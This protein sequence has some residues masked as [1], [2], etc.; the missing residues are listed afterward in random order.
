MDVTYQHM[1]VTKTHVH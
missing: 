1:A